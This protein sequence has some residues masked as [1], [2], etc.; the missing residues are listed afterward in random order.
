VHLVETGVSQKGSL[1]S[2]RAPRCDDLSFVRLA[3]ATYP[4]STNSAVAP[5]GLPKNTSGTLGNATLASQL[6]V[7]CRAA[8]VTY[9][10]R[11]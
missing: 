4:S 11:R 10:K 1:V 7:R 9:A 8:F 2:Y 6:V 5:A 3:H